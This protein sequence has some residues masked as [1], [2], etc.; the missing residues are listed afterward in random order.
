MSDPN[1]TVLVLAAGKGT[2]M[3][4]QHAKVLHQ[5][6]FRPMLLHVLEAARTAG[7][8]QQV[9]IVGHQRDRVRQ[10]L[11]GHEV[12]LVVQEQQQGT[13][14]AVL[15]AEAAC[16][17]PTVCILCGDTPL[18][19]PETL[20]AM[21]AQHRQRR[22]DLTL[23]TTMLEQ[24]F[25]YGR[26]L[27]DAAGAITAI[28]EEKDA[29]PK[30]RAIRE[31]NA[32]IYLAERELLFAAL[33]RVGSNNSQG[34]VYLTDVVGLARAMGRVVQPFVHPVALDVLGVNS[35]LELAQAE[36]EL[37]GRR[38]R[39]LMLAGVT[40]IQPATVAVAPEVQVGQDCL[41]HPQVRISGRSHL[42]SDCSI[43]SGSLLHDCELGDGVG[44]GPYCV[45][46]GC[47]LA[48]GT[49][50]PPLTVRDEAPC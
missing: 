26:V 16:R 4:S 34:E 5:A 22:A 21:L 50:I 3:K 49:I 20:T 19:R 1:I 2:R 28:V 9:V 48:A 7:M 35:R 39:E 14:H 6:F 31:I 15:C 13:G 23:M 11:T 24:P 42:G 41:L 47:R 17:T 40:I 46:T 12:E 29:D 37:Q 18:I 8:Q 27:R 44:I 10:A 30:Q 45:L 25:G 33:K 43:G 38:N 36:A 32:G